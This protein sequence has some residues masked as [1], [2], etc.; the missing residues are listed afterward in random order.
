MAFLYGLLDPDEVCYMEQPEGF[1]EVRMEDH[2]WELQRGLYR[3]KQGGVV[4]NRTMNK[5]MLDWGFMQ[6]KCKHCVY[7]QCT[8]TG[9]VFSLWQSMLTICLPLGVPKLQL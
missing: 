5:A 1:V 4:W 3:M 8:D 7:Y 2:V 6:L 9:M